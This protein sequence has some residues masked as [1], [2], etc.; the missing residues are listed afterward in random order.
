MVT[1]PM[2]RRTLLLLLFLGALSLRLFAAETRD[3]LVDR[4][5][6]VVNN[7]IITQSEFD[8]IFRPFYEQMKKAY[9]GSN[10]NRELQDLRLKLLNQLIEDKLVYQEAKKLGITVSDS[11][12]EEETAQFKKQ[13]KDEAAFQKEMDV[14]GIKFS[15]IEERFRERLSI[16]KLHQYVIRGNVIISPAEMEQY[17]KDHREEFRQKENVKLWCI[18]IPKSEEAA[19]KGI[20]DEKAKKKAQNLLAEL[21]RSAHFEELAKKNSQDS[22]APEGGLIGVVTKGDM[23]ANLDKA[24][25]LLSENQASEVLETEAAYHIF[26]VA[27]KKPA[28][29]LTFEEARDSIH[30]QLF[31]VKSHERFVSWMDELKKKAY[32]SIR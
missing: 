23:I 19:H 26:K 29:D 3:Q 5:A 4:V 31:R 21:R 12:L 10:L 13:F 1:V 18:T 6:A 22:H 28:S 20:M 11:E 14:I 17:Y 24:I 30:D 25:F 9:Q 27:Q 7:E 8:L 16:E 32:I 2:K 15:E